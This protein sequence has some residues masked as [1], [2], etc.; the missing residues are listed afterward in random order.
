MK[1]FQIREIDFIAALAANT[2]SVWFFK[3]RVTWAKHKHDFAPR[4]TV[5]W[6]IDS[7]EGEVGRIGLMVN[8]DPAC[9]HNW[10][11]RQVTG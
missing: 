2:V 4:V 5:C 3:I 1:S 6:V 11:A 7:S 9:V 8:I 10:R